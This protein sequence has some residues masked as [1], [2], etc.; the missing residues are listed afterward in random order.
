MVTSVFLHPTKAFEEGYHNPNVESAVIV[1]LITAFLMALAVYFTM[2]NLFASVFMFAVNIIQWIIYSALVWFFEF[3]HV[4]KRKKMVGAEF[5]QIL[6]VVGKLWIINLVGA[7]IFA[8][9]AIVLPI[10]SKFVLMI[11]GPVLLLA[12]LIVTVAW[13]VA[14][15]KMLKVVFGADRLKLVINWVILNFLNG[16]VASFVTAFLAR[17]LF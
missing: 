6:S 3:V 7:A 16:V 14:S 2:G 5:S 12:L 13:F 17:L 10:S 8:I 4:R 1:V 11:L 15:F 9:V